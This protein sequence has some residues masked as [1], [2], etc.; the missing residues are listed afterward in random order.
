MVWILA[1][2][3]RRRA[4]RHEVVNHP[5]DL[6]SVMQPR[7]ATGFGLAVREQRSGRMRERFF[8]FDARIFPPVCAGA[9]RGNLST[10]SRCDSKDV[11]DR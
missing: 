6:A 11:C 5:R 8:E 10:T 2:Q 9:D 4:V 1:K 7:C 3:P